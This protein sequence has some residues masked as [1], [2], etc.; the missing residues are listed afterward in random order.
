MTDLL[1]KALAA[2]GG[3]Q[4][5][6]Q[7]DALKARVS[8]S[9]IMFGMKGK[10]DPYRDA[11]VIVERERPRTIYTPFAGAGRRGVFE[12]SRVAVETIEGELL[13]ARDEPRKSFASHKRETQWDDLH[14][15]Y[16]TGY[17]MWNYLWNPFFLTFP[18]FELSEIE[19][20]QEDGETWRRLAAK[21]PPG[22][23]THCSQ[24]VFYFD[25]AGLLRRLDYGADVLGGAP[26]AHYCYD[27]KDFSGIVLPTRRR[28]MLRGPDNHPQP[29]PVAVSIEIH[30]AAPN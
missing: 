15:I 17:A 2:Q 28:A 24:Q 14:L 23:P 30:D 3:L 11:E 13:E 7:I 19:P 5:W 6:R 20:W 27:H 1:E 10:P 21:F 22:I 9:G 26:V 25:E 29:G 18:G 12:A 4:R 16:F 8:V